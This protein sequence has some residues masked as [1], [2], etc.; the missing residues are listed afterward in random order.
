[1]DALDRYNEVTEKRQITG[2][3]P[4]HIVQGE[5][6]S[7]L[8]DDNISE[9]TQLDGVSNKQSDQSISDINSI[10]SEDNQLEIEGTKSR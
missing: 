4:L 10:F 9:I 5:V 7:I 6:D 3:S 2:K 8:D 1:M